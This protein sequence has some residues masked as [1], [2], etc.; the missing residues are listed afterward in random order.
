MLS[1]NETPAGVYETLRG[2]SFI[3]VGTPA[4]IHQAAARLAR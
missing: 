4:Q 1:R 3:L 2:E